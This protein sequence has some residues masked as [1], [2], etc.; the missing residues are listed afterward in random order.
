[1]AVNGCE[2]TAHNAKAEALTTYFSSILGTPTA[3]VW[4]FNLADIYSGT[5][6]PDLSDLAAPIIE[7]EARAAVQHMN[8]NSAPGP[9]GFGPGFFSAAWDTVSPKVMK[10]V[11]AFAQG[12]V[13]LERV[14]RAFVVLIPKK[15]GATAPGDHRPIRLQNCPM[16]IIGKILTS[17]LQAHIPKLIDLDQTGFIKGRSISENFIYA[18]ELVQHCHKQR[19]PTLVLKLDFAKAFDSVN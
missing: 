9:D 13:D 1:M 7:S 19:L 15:P 3:A 14:N 8:R 2:L 11:E 18:M 16:K 17:R 4:H 12:T 5:P 10:F 6:T